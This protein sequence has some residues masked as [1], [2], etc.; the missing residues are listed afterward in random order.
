MR[1]E[2]EL[3]S[4]KAVLDGLL[5]RRLDKNVSPMEVPV[6]ELHA[7]LRHCQRGRH[8]LKHTLS[9]MKVLELHNNE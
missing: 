3:L 6:L 2:F 9:L 1:I 7:L 4:I 8:L 5:L